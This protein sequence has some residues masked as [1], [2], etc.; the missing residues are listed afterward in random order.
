MRRLLLAL[1]LAL[2]PAGSAGAADRS[3]LSND[4][5]AFV[6]AGLGA[7]GDKVAKTDTAAAFSLGYRA[8]PELEFLH[9]RPS[10]D[11]LISNEATVYGWLGL[12]LD[13]FLGSRFV[14]TP[15]IGVGGYSAGGGQS[16]G[17]VILFRTG[18][19]LSLRFDNHARVGL[20]VHHLSNLGL[21]HRNPGVETVGLYFA[22]PFNR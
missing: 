3:P 20:G 22:L 15:Q 13:L 18:G 5:P 17:H 10:L 21:G 12:G 9:I 2:L 7:M 8:G 11:L 6:I 1:A 4:D 19:T 14:F 16:L